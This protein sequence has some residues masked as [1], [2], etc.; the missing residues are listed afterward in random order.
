M[1]GGI[2]KKNFHCRI[3]TVVEKSKVVMRL[4]HWIPTNS[5][6]HS[7]TLWVID[8]HNEKN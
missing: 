6:M 2:K 7:G 8:T 5:E 3:D 1:G 4:L